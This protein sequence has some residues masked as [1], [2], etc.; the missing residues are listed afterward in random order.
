MQR[1][2]ISESGLPVL[3]DWSNP[4]SLQDDNIQNSTTLM[5][6][7]LELQT[8]F[9]L[10][11]PKFNRK[12]QAKYGIATCQ[13]LCCCSINTGLKDFAVF[14]CIFLC[15]S[16][17]EEIRNSHILCFHYYQLF[18]SQVSKCSVLSFTCSIRMIATIKR[19]T[20]KDSEDIVMGQENEEPYKINK[21]Q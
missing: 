11:D 1:E 7:S 20:R 17:R 12:L 9:H 5:N 8:Q 18:Y 21:D 3:Q 6:H 16:R 10:L 13:V 2:N 4:C 19:T 15:L 14:C